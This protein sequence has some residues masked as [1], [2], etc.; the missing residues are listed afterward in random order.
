MKPFICSALSALICLISSSALAQNRVLTVDNNP[1]AVAMFK[2]IT[3]AYEAAKGGDTILLA[4]SPNQYGQLVIKKRLNLV[5]PGY[6]LAENKIPGL[7]TQYAYVGISLGIGPESSSA[8]STFTG[9][10]LSIQPDSGITGA[11]YERIGNIIIDRC[12]GTGGYFDYQVTIRRSLITGHI[13]LQASGS[14]IRN[15]IIGGPEFGA[16]SLNL[17]GGTTAANCVFA[18]LPNT[19]ELSSISS[20]IFALINPDVTAAQYAQSVKGSVSYSMA[21]APAPL[22]GST[23]KGA[24][25]LPVGGG[26]INGIATELVFA[27]TG[28]VD[29]KWKLRANS[30]AMGK[31]F[32]GVD[33]G[34]F[35]GP[36]PYILGGVPSIPRVTRFVVPAAVTSTS[37]LRF[38]VDAQSF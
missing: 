16:V 36:S 31:G 9:L 29:A 17:K 5:G 37:G 19:E 27:G 15:S 32:D 38:E 21:V 18:A 1:G 34:A 25:F 6:Y 12:F 14:S 30:P 26:N 8:G 13:H 11:A 3:D 28:A 24:N 20:S 10:Y 22:F 33:M 23:F 7:S 2:N 4:G 35:G